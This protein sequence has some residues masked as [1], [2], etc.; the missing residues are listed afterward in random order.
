M[1]FSREALDGR[2]RP[3]SP[4]R[5]S[6]SP[7]DA[8]PARRR[9]ARAADRP[10]RRARGTRSRSACTRPEA[11]GPR[12]TTVRSL[13]PPPPLTNADKVLYP[14]DNL[15]KRDL[16]RLLPRR[17]ARPLV[18]HLVDR[19]VVVQRWPDG[20]DEFDWYQHRVPPRAP[21]Y[22]RAAWVDGGVRRIV[23]ENGDALLWLV[24]QAGLTFHGFASRLATLAE[25]DF[26]VID[27]DPGDR[28]TWANV[29][30]IATAVRKIL[31]LLELPSVIKTSGQ[32]GVLR[33]GP[34][35]ARAHS[36]A[37]VRG[38]RRAASPACS[39]RLLPDKVTLEYEKEKR[40]GRLLVDTRQ[41]L[42][43]TLVVAYSLRAA[44]G[45]TVSTPL[46][47]DELSPALDPRTFTLRTLRDRL[48]RHG[49]L[50]AP[51]RGGTRSSLGSRARA[52]ARRS[53]YSAARS[54][55]QR[56][57]RRHLP[58][59]APDRRDHVDRQLDAVQLAR[60]QPRKESR[61]QQAVAGQDLHGPQRRVLRRREEAARPGQMP[62]AR[63]TG[64]S[65]RTASRG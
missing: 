55:P 47:W 65:G 9:R 54:A 2:R 62:E 25:P 11:R 56:A 41:H 46:A 15:C 42:A 40:G 51:L 60:S 30:E 49:D 26:A 59:G 36:F 45:A 44:D 5:C 27:L 6:P 48:D 16:R 19:P 10:L 7:T 64:S 12:S 29:V 28:T 43:K 53:A 3:R 35:R 32:R 22:I 14:R 24:N 17:R 31:E 52:T 18:P 23:I 33:A 21:D 58:V 37:Q 39:L 4:P 20:I 50:A 8:R 63:C 57:A 61:G 13:S 1:P 34:A 38:A